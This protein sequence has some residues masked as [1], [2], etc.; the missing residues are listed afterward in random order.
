[1]RRRWWSPD[2]DHFVPGD[3]AAELAATGLTVYRFSA[4]LF[5]ANANLF[6]EEIQKLVKRAPRPVKW[7]V[8]DA[9]AMMDMDTTGAEAM[10]QL[11]E[12]Y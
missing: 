6:S 1:M 7:F 8:L 10:R 3:K 4:P 2:G 5:F 9:D 12:R 11:L